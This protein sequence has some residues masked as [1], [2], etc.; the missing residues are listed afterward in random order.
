MSERYQLEPQ[1]VGS[2]GFGKVYK[3]TDKVLGRAVAIKTLDRLLV[4]AD[5]RDRER[6]AQEA[7]TLARF[8]H[9]NIPAIYDVAFEDELRIIFQ[10]IQGETV[11]SLLASGPLSLP[12][13][14]KWF[15]QIASALQHAHEMNIIHRDLKPENLIVTADRQH[16]YLVD[17][18]IAL[19]AAQL[20][21]LTE[22]H[23]RI[24][25]PG[26]MSPEQE[27]GDTL[28]PSD[29]LYVLGKCLYEALSG[30]SIAAGNY[31]H[32]S[33]I[34]E[35]IPPAIDDL[36]LKCIDPKPRRLSS[37]KDFARLLE[38]ALSVRRSLSEILTG[39]K[40][41]EIS[42]AIASMSADDFLKI[43]DGQRRLI[44]STCKDVIT[45]GG[46]DLLQARRDFLLYLTP[47]SIWMS[48]ADCA[49]FV[50]EALKA[51]YDEGHGSYIGDR[52]IRDALATAASDA[53]EGSLRTIVDCFL[54]WLDNAR[55]DGEEPWFFHEV[56]MLVKH[57]MANAAC[58]AQRAEKLQEILEKVNHLQRK[59]TLRQTDPYAATQV[60]Y[61]RPLRAQ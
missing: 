31:G 49:I 10:F 37:A 50:S 12:E 26:Y 27:R 9:P 1:E 5:D 3:A 55:L 45:A 46:E 40:L 18:G 44:I 17:F 47:L 23:E 57:L 29:D 28:D 52:R 61:H 21:R 59:T 34:N 19:S 36:I 33:V 16:C 41:H 43:P 32:L 20:K 24:G 30:Q 56:R 53:A 2:G 51:A 6:F 48:T 14:Q 25:T 22:S 15:R 42:Q 54:S 38:S 4:D 39:G 60:Q 11:R 35:T 7:K 58:D 13:V 8:S